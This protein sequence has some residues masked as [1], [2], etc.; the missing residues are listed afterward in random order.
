MSTNPYDSPESRPAGMSGSNKLLLGLGIGC[1]LLVVI[2]C[3]GGGLSSYFYFQNVKNSLSKDPTRIRE[4]TAEI[5]TI[6]VPEALPP[7]MCVSIPIPLTGKTFM[8]MAMYGDEGDKNMM[9]LMQFGWQ[10]D[11]QQMNIQW[12]N[13]M[14]T[15]GRR[16]IEDVDIEQTETRDLEINGRSAQFRIASGQAHKTNRKVW[17]VVG[18][19]NGKGGSAMLFLQMNQDDLSKEDLLKMLD[20]MK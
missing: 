20:S 4:V 8:T 14:R 10:M 17:Q 2:C 13:Q 1:G 12:R 7:M 3:G 11:E 6:E 15:S 5:V 19:F 18:T 9:V 16:D